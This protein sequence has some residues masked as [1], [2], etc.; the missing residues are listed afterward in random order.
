MD[1][2][3]T[4]RVTVNLTPEVLAQVDQFAAEN[5]WTRST[6]IAVLIEQGLPEDGDG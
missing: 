5:R 2:V 4:E 1:A 3:R 6:A